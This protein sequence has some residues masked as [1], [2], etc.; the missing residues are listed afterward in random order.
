MSKS[1]TPIIKGKRT[2]K[3]SSKAAIAPNVVVEETKEAEK[4]PVGRPSKYQDTFP[5]QARKLCLLGATD[6]ELADF[7]EVVEDTINEWKVAHKEFSVSIKEGKSEADS[8]VADR[9]YKRAL[10]YTHQAVKI[11]ANPTT[12]AEQI[13]PFTEHYAPDTTACIFWLKNRQKDKWRDKQEVDVTATVTTQ[14]EEQR[15]ARI[16]ELQAKLNAKQG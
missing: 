16:A 15:I 9:L 8:N 7:F 3:T 2:A 5:E 1:T 12:G 11:F 10:G 14:T 6:K 13:V 4:A